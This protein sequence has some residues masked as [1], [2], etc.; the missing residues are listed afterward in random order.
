MGRACL[1]CDKNLRH[2]ILKNSIVIAKWHDIWKC[3]VLSLSGASIKSMHLLL[4]HLCL[5]HGMPHIAAVL[6][7][8]LAFAA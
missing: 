6:N 3:S 7:V 2:W 5:M 1:D 4:E 8:T